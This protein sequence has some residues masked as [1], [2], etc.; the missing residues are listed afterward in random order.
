MYFWYTTKG[1]YRVIKNNSTLVSPRGALAHPV[2]GNATTF[3]R[4]HMEKIECSSAVWCMLGVRVA[5]KL[6]C[7]TLLKAFKI[8]C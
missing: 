2:G 5:L 1:I 7:D 4:R 3:E 8:I 6:L